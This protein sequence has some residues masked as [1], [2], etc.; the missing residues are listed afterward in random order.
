MDEREEFAVADRRAGQTYFV[1]TEEQ[2]K[3]IV[4][5]AGT[6]GAR[7]AIDEFI[8]LLGRKTLRNIG[9]A[10]AAALAVATTWLTDF[11]HLTFG[12]K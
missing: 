9:I 10:L 7:K 2:V 11:V 3:R 8:A 5:E 6:D 1:F 4:S 12:Q